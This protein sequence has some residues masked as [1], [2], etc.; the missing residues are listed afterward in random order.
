[1]YRVRGPGRPVVGDCMGERM[2]IKRQEEGR[3]EESHEE[4]RLRTHV[5][6]HLIIPRSEERKFTQPAGNGE[7]RL[8]SRGVL[9]PFARYPPPLSPIGSRQRYTEKAVGL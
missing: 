5:H 7:H 9:Q 3:G 8:T 1:M 4:R 2:K 6:V